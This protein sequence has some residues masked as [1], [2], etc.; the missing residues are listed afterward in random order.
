MTTP[1][2]EF[3]PNPEDGTINRGRRRRRP[4]WWRL[5]FTPGPWRQTLYAVTALPI[6]LGGSVVA[7]LGGR[8][9]RSRVANLQRRLVDRFVAPSPPLPAP[10]DDLVARGAIVHGLL[11]APL[12]LVAAAVT[13]YGWSLLLVNVAY[14]L[15]P[16]SGDL[17]S[18]WGGPSLAGA[19]AVHA[20]GVLPFLFL[21]PWVVHWLTSLQAAT[22]R[23][24]LR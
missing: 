19:W 22:A 17:E 13:I 11:A 1:V 16:D 3:D 2:D 18:S 6:G 7:L 20:I 5:P 10:D 15:R 4:S 8:S 21:M 24:L 12:N 9:A 14:P 23:R